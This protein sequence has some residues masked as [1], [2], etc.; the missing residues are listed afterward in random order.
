[1]FRVRWVIDASNVIG[2]RPD[3]WWRDRD[4]ATRRLVTDLERFAADTGEPVTVVL[5]AGPRDLDSDDVEIVRARP[6]GRDAADDEIVALLEAAHDPSDHRVV[7]SDAK[8]AAR[9][10]ELGADVQGAGRFRR[11]LDRVDGPDRR[12]PG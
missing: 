3:G 1:V 10:R 11:A 4:G 6:R 12:A 8:L 7:T 5:D 9:V 2:S